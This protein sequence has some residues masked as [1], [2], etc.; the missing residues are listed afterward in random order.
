MAQDAELVSLGSL[1]VDREAGL[2]ILA[3]YQFE[4]RFRFL[5]PLVRCAVLSGASKM[6]VFSTGAGIEAWFDG[7]P[8]SGAT[9]LDPFGAL[10]AP[11]DGTRERD[12]QLAIA[13]VA[14]L[15]TEPLSVTVA[16]GAGQA[17]AVG[18]PVGEGRAPSAP[19]GLSNES[20]CVSFGWGFPDQMLFPIECFERVLE[21]CGF[22]PLE[23]SAGGSRAPRRPIEARRAPYEASAGGIRVALARPLPGDEGAV[24]YYK[25]GV[26]VCRT[27]WP[28]TPRDI[29]AHIDAADLRL[30]IGQSGVVRDEAWR[31]AM[32]L[33]E[34]LGPEMEAGLKPPRQHWRLC[35]VLSFLCT[36]SFAGFLLLHLIRGDGP[37]PAYIRLRLPFYTGAML[38]C[39]AVSGV[40]SL[41]SVWLRVGDAQTAA[42]CALSAFATGTMSLFLVT[43]FADATN[44]LG[45]SF[46]LFLVLGGVWLR[47]PPR[48][49]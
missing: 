2:R 37:D 13:V 14:S 42:F 32:D 22:V 35:A 48:S 18:H 45:A 16:S 47:E 8:L 6:T 15:R 7:A 4:D 36:A 10:F 12:L 1:K 30:D 46:L 38:F 11:E 31:R 49:G 19:F 23:L 20:T 43:E 24:T 44:W 27:A 39:A 29:E 5:A 28:G 41:R 17:R 21:D 33:L 25:H 3:R 9:V 26:R 34:K 40:L